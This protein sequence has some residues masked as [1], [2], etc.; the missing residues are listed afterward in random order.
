MGTLYVLTCV[1]SFGIQ[2]FPYLPGQVIR[3]KGLLDK[4]NP[5]IQNAVVDNSIIRVSGHEK[6]F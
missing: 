1:S 5:L 2:H 6:D 4:G 3:G